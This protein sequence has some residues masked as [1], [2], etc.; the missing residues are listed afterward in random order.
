MQVIAR[1]AGASVVPSGHP[2]HG[3]TSP[4][5][6]DGRGIFDG[7]PCPFEA[8]RYHSLVVD[9]L[10]V[11]AELETSAWSPDGT[12]MGIRAHQGMTEGVLFH[13]ESFLT[14]AGPRMF[15]NFLAE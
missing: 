3:K 12:L 15:S 8:A 6:H 11:P 2:V 13:P 1:V 4:V 5:R 7:L 9:P 14:E 10:T